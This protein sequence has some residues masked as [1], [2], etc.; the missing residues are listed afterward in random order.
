VAWIVRL[1][2]IGA[3]GE[4]QA[5]D[6][7]EIDRPDDLSDI[8]DLD[9]TL[10]EAKLLLAGHRQV[11]GCW[12]VKSAIDRSTVI[13]RR[14]HAAMATPVTSAQVANAWRRAE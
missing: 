8:A 5:T 9:L 14:D 12:I 13:G 11:V 10:A 6:I 1:V 7:I 2:Q 4:G 3:E